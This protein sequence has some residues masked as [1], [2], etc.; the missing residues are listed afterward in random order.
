MRA[1]P[2]DNSERDTG[3]RPVKDRTGRPPAAGPEAVSLL[4]LQRTAG[5]AAVARMLDQERHSHGPG[6]GHGT[7]ADE[8]APVQR[9]AVHEVLRTPGAPLE[10]GLR[11]EMEARLGA[12]FSDVRMH[13]DQA[14]RRSAAEIGAR[15]YTSGSHVVVGEGGADRHTLAHELTHVVQQRQ[16]PVAGTDHGDGLRV[17]DPSDRFEREA[18]ANAHRVLAAALPTTTREDTGRT[19]GA[20][21][22]RSA[23]EAAVQRAPSFRQTEESGESD[24]DAALRMLDR[25]AR[26][27]ER[28]ILATDPRA[29]KKFTPYL[30]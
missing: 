4:H 3:T 14:A 19:G 21:Q 11:S 13:T 1:R 27:A 25:V 6:C 12:D 24:R 28:V 7:A 16:G 18:E 22:R 30:A 20:A 29:G 5:N 23:P 15:A 10:A 2:Q 8:A 9:S 17:S 26:T